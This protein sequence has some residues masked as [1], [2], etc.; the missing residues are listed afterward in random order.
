M[1]FRT[2]VML[3][4]LVVHL[5]SAQVVQP[6]YSANSIL[7]GASFTPGPFAPNSFISIFGSTLAYDTASLPGNATAVPLNLGS[8]EVYINNQ[9]QPLFYVSPTQINLLLQSNLL[10]GTATLYVVRQGIY[11]PQIP[12]TLAATAPQ[13]FTTSDSFVI[14]QHADYSLVTSNAPANPGEIIVLYATGLGATDPP[15]DPNGVIPLFPGLVTTP[16]QVLLN[17]SALDPSQIQYAGLTPGSAGIYQVNVQLPNQLGANP[18]IQ[19]SAGGQ[20]SV[21]NV[22]LP[23]QPSS[24]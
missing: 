16:V 5:A 10:L 23:T 7:N 8:V 21:G 18:Q 24:N 11:G 6:A 3:A 17:G 15:P 14:A 1:L 4:A 13:L 20:T 12:I 9:P 22:L 2:A 19:L